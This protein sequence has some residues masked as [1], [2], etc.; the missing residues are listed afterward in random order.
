MNCNNC[1][2]DGVCKLKDEFLKV[3]HI[4]KEYHNAFDISCNYYIN[5]IPKLVLKSSINNKKLFEQIPIGKITS[6]F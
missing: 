3:I 5:D 6:T 2:H 1:I 4:S